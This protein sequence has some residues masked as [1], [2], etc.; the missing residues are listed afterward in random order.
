MNQTD[1][2]SA[3][4]YKYISG[5]YISYDDGNVNEVA[6]ISSNSA[7]AVKITV[8]SGMYGKLTTVLIRN[9]MDTN[10]SNSDMLFHVWTNN[11]GVPGNDLITPFLVTPEA[12]LTS[13]FPYTR[14]D[15]RSYSEQLSDLTDD[16]FVG[17]TVPANTVN[18]V[19]SHNLT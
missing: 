1:T 9:Y 18:L 15:L 13:P 8:P 4:E 3:T 10:L 7:A 5:S 17:F 14:I 11:S 19:V 12:T 2:A 16:I 6:T